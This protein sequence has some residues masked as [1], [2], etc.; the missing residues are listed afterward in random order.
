MLYEKEKTLTQEQSNTKIVLLH[1]GCNQSFIARTMGKD[2]SVVS[3]EIKRNSSE[4]R[5]LYNYKTAQQKAD[6][7]K[8]G[9]HRRRTFTKWHQEFVQKHLKEK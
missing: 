2:R 8:Q 3:R 6:F 1:Q 7:R 9:F 5:D 4:K